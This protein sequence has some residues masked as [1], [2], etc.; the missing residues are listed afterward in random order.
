MGRFVFFGVLVSMCA[1]G[2]DSRPRGEV[3]SGT[4]RFDSGRADSGARVDSGSVVDSGIAVDSGTADDAGTL[5]DAGQD[6]GAMCV[7]AGSGPCAGEGAQPCCSGM[8][9]AGIPLP[10]DGR[11]LDTDACPI[12]DRN[13]K[14]GFAAVDNE[15]VLETLAAIPIS[16]WSYDFEA[17]NVRHMGP[18]AQD[19]HAAFGLGADDRH[20]P[21]I[22]S[23]GVSFAAIQALR[24]RTE[25]LDEA[26][27]ALHEENAR[28][29][30]QLEALDARLDAIERRS[31]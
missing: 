7:P 17:G 5:A 20:I 28:L 11:C 21:V 1:C 25:Q 19:F 6:A 12:S 9:C 22:D 4:T 8:C 23:A 10:D 2:G 18:M 29:R 3:D 24:A 16:T 31:R 13:V 30:A 27:S 14:H 26:N 15:A